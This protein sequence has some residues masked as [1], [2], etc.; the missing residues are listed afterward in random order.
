VPDI[1]LPMLK[2]GEMRE[3]DYEPMPGTYWMHSHVPCR[4]WNCWQHP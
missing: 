2:P 4:K 1:P 3:F